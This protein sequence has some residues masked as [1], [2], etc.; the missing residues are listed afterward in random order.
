MISCSTFLLRTLL[1]YTGERLQLADA[2]EEL[3]QGYRR[4]NDN[5][6]DE[7]FTRLLEITSS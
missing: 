6:S 1:R 2:T 5:I 3:M 4:F 7:E